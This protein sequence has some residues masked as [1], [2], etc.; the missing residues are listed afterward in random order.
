MTRQ[1]RPL[2]HRVLP[3]LAAALLVVSPVFAQPPAQPLRTE[4]ISVTPPPGWVVSVWQGGT[5]EIG[6]FTPAGETGGKYV[7]LLGYSVLPK[8]V[9]A[10]AITQTA[11]PARERREHAQDCQQIV[12]R[13]RQH[14]DGWYSS[15]SICIGRK[16]AVASEQVAVSFAVQRVGEQALFRV[17]REWRGTP[18]ELAEMLKARTGKVLMPVTGQGSRQR[19]NELELDEAF[20]ALVPVFAPDLKRSE[21]CDLRAPGG[22]R[23]FQG[24][25]PVEATARLRGTLIAG[26]YGRGL[27]L[28]SREEFRRRLGG[29]GA[30]DEL[31]RVFAIREPKDLDWSD[32]SAVDNVILVVGTGIVTDGGS[33]VASDPN[34]DM[35]AEQRVRV[36]IE[37]LMSGRRLWRSGYRP[38]IITFYVPATR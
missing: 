4:V 6:E 24:V 8:G 30:D 25:L 36:R 20:A 7:D 15:Q 9:G 19:V 22:C 26:F 29:T 21:I 33:L 35:S 17:W 16:G 11:L 18:T 37:V 31:H 10:T 38:D 23:A 5:F 34:E 12:L 1:G 14:L 3:A 28:I 13:E 27:N 32:R 2:L